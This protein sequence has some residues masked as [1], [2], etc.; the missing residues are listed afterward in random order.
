MLSVAL[1]LHTQGTN[2]TPH[3]H[4]NLES[5]PYSTY[6]QGEQFVRDTSGW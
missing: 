4:N 1:F 2:G 5:Q 3:G 6:C